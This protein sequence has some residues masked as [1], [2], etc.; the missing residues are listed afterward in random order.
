MEERE[1]WSFRVG[2]LL[3]AAGSAIG[4]GNLWR[5]PFLTAE[6]GGAVFLLVYL[7]C[8]VCIGFPLLIG[9]L[10]IGRRSKRNAI[11]AF[12]RLGYR[13]WRVAGVIAVFGAFILFSYYSVVGGWVIQYALANLTGGYGTDPE[14]FFG[15]T[16]T[17]LNA[18]FYQG[19]FLFG[20]AAVVAYGV[21]NG[22]ERAAT[23]LVPSIILLLLGLVVYGSTLSGARAAYS[24]YLYPDFVALTE[25]ITV[26][27]PAA[28]GQAFFSLSL[29]YALILTYASYIDEDRN[30]VTDGTVIVGLDTAIAVLAGLVVFPFLFTQ[31]IAPGDG[32]PGAVFVSL[33]T[34]F[35]SLP[36]GNVLGSVF[37]LLLLLAALTSAFALL[38]ILVSVVIDT[39]DVSRRRA[40]AGMTLA[41]FLAGVPTALNATVFE[42]YD[43]FLNNVVLVFSGLLLSIFIGWI[44]AA[45]MGEELANGRSVGRPFDTFW[46]FALRYAVPLV[47]LVTLAFGVVSY[48]QFLNGVFL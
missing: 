5:F 20:T 46:L 13:E 37:F 12:S 7:L 1:T 47:L 27:L 25:N 6:S 19:L 24:Y 48:A 16:S 10:V 17:G 34:A 18:V 2:F 45:G 15:A 29:G 28:A 38:E 36:A 3:A 42:A 26:I 40:T 9:E 39:F 33:A 23:V 32:G 14:T 4:L 35:S 21:R 43:L 31:G 44:A 30:L 8:V 22:I 41:V 11:G